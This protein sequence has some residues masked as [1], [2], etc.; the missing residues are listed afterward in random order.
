ML[1]PR[2]GIRRLLSLMVVMAAI[3]FVV[4]QAVLGRAWAYGVIAAVGFGVL[5]FVTFASF[6]LLVFLL[7]RVLP[8]RKAMVAESPFATDKLPP[9]IIPPREP[10]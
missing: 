3:F 10:T 4:R 9:Q 5:L 8:V 6:F 2:F 1:F 7:A